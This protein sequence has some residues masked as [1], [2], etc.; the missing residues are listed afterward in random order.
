RAMGVSILVYSVFAGLGA[1]TNSCNQMSVLRFL[2]GLGVG[3]AWPNA[4]AL[5]DE[6]RPSAAIRHTISGLV[7]FSPA[8]KILVPRAASIPGP[9]PVTLPPPAPQFAAP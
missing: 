1:W 7:D 8:S 2:V 3:G 5:V 4:V 9:R 6:T